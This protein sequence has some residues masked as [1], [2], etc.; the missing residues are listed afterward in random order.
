MKK[1]VFALLCALILILSLTACAEETQALQ[2]VVPAF[3]LI[4]VIPDSYKLIEENWPDPY[5]G[6]M[7]ITSDQPGKPTLM[8]IVA[9]NDVMHDIT[10]NDEGME[11]DIVKAYIEQAA[12]D[13]ET[14]VSIPYTI[15]KTGL[16]TSI[17]IFDYAD[18]TEFYSIWHGYEVSLSAWDEDENGVIINVSDQQ[19]DMILQF[20]TD[21][22]ITTVVEQ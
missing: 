13:Y 21:L 3:R 9:Y 20:L 12:Q 15:R 6:T 22:D 4:P 10:F 8:L 16:G 2:P 18:S 5:L 17:V 11:T 19:K 1:T 14:G 7:L